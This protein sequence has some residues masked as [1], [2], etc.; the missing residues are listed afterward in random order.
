MERI[1]YLKFASEPLEKRDREKLV[2]LQP[3][4]PCVGVGGGGGA[5]QSI[6]ITP[7]VTQLV[8]F[9]LLQLS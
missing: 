5:L 9:G 8:I 6:K 1:S 2:E 3:S 7:Q 4:L